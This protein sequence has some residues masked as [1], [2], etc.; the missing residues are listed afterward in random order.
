MHTA[1]TFIENTRPAL[2]SGRGLGSSSLIAWLHGVHNAGFLQ[3]IPRTFQARMFRSG[4]QALNP[5]THCGYPPN[6]AACATAAAL[7]SGTSA[8]PIAS[9]GPSSALWL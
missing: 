2:I 6:P 3:Q 5:A 9:P 1:F 7:G 4:S 8:L